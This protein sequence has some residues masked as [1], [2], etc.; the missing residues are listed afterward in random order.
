[1]PSKSARIL[2]ERHADLARASAAL[3][4]LLQTAIQRDPYQE[5]RDIELNYRVR[6]GIYRYVVELSRASSSVESELRRRATF[7]TQA[8]A[9]GTPYAAAEAQCEFIYDPLPGP[10]ARCVATLALDTLKVYH[11]ARPRPAGEKSDRELTVRAIAQ[12]A[13][14]LQILI[15]HGRGLRLSDEQWNLLRGWWSAADALTQEG[16]RISTDCC[17]ILL[18]LYESR[19]QLRPAGERQGWAILLDTSFLPMYFPDLLE[20]ISILDSWILDQPASPKASPGNSSEL[21][22]EN[23]VTNSGGDLAPVGTTKLIGTPAQGLLVAADSDE[24]SDATATLSERQKAKEARDNWIYE[25]VMGGDKYSTIISRLKN[26]MP[27]SWTR[28]SSVGGIRRAADAFAKRNCLS[29]PR[30][31]QPGR[32]ASKRRIQNVRA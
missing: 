1:M 9:A 18:S 26:E 20:S 10:F 32:I 21:R 11:T 25:Q 23:S 2:R 5:A 17:A 31:R 4:K 27:S 22:A 7:I 29:R 3:R 16:Q 24:Q 15:E 28:I 6:E 19:L 13:A 8:T 14:A 30:T 12:C